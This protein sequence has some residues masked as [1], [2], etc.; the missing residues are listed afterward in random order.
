M[1]SQ[2]KG[3]MLHAY[4]PQIPILRARGRSS[5]TMWC[6]VLIS[7]LCRSTC[8]LLRPPWAR[9]VARFMVKRSLLRHTA[10]A[11]ASLLFATRHMNPKTHPRVA[12]L[13]YS[14]SGTS[15][16]NLMCQRYL[17]H[18]HGESFLVR[19]RVNSRRCF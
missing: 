13:L 15:I 3:H 16:G 1:I 12:I 7:E 2:V 5:Y 8:D 10:I 19:G 9:E 4:E 14:L 18:L 6:K 11:V 17:R